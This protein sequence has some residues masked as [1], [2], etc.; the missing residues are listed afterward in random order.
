MYNAQNLKARINKAAKAKG[1]SVRSVLAECGLNPNTVNQIKDEKG[2]SC[3]A[4]AQIADCLDCSVD[5]LLGRAEWFSGEECE[6]I[7]ND[8]IE[9]ASARS[10]MENH[11]GPVVLHYDRW[12]EIAKDIAAEEGKPFAARA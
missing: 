1:L 6:R 9:G 7:V 5:F 2:L 4:L 10:L 8:I 3:F 12:R 11:G